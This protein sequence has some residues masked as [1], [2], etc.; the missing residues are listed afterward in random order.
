MEG[1]M[2]QMKYRTRTFYTEAQ[3]AIMWERWRKGESLHD[4]ARLFD[5]H[6]SSIGA[7]LSES[8][9]IRPPQRVRSSRSLS[10]SDREE[11]SRGVIAGRSMRSIA[12]SLGRAISTVSR[13]IRRN[14]GCDD[15]RANNAD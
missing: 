10:L 8:G 9:G 14:G 1:R 6:H 13:E 15:Y 3:K 4:I 11:I 5:R 7:I 2:L 12:V